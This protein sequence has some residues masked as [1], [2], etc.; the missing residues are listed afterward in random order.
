MFLTKADTLAFIKD[1]VKK[2]RVE[3]IMIITGKEFLENENQS[4]FDIKKRFGDNNIV[5]RSSSSN[6]DSLR[7]SNAGHYESVL[8]VPAGDESAVKKAVQK[9]LASYKKDMDNIDSE[10][11][12]IQRQT[13]KLSCSG[14]I[15]SKDI[16]LKRPYYVISYD[17][18]STDAVTSGSGGK[19]LYIARSANLRELPSSWAA[20]IDAVRELEDIFP[21]YP[22]DIEFAIDENNDVIIFQVSQLAACINDKNDNISHENVKNDNNEAEIS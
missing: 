5:I 8:N 10:Q 11:V 3:D 18:H 4:A 2:S 20:L 19:T 7:S 1:R 6:E 12:L 17:T 9:V 16:K 21:E 15:F 14:V 22:L 13:E